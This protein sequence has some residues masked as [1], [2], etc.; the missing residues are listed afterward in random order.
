MNQQHKTNKTKRK[1]NKTGNSN[2]FGSHFLIYHTIKRLRHSKYFACL[3]T[4][5]IVYQLFYMASILTT[6]VFDFQDKP[7]KPRNFSFSKRPFWKKTDC[8]K[9]LSASMVFK[10]EV[11]SL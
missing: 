4:C 6:Y 11:A 1:I 8:S 5:F 10:M 7:H 2:A 3:I 9:K